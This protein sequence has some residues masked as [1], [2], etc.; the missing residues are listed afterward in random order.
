[1][2]IWQKS[3]IHCLND[4][5]YKQLQSKTTSVHSSV[6][7]SNCP[8]ITVKKNVVATPGGMH[9]CLGYGAGSPGNKGFSCLASSV[10]SCVASKLLRQDKR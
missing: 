2:N 10:V 4:L 5:M 1:M 3:L 7:V 6:K 8:A 9:S